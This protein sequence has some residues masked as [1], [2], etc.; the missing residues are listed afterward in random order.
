[1]RDLGIEIEIIRLY[2]YFGVGV[3]EG[4]LFV[5]L[6]FCKNLMVKPASAYLLIFLGVKS[7]KTLKVKSSKSW[8]SNLKEL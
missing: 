4:E 3:G 5:K 6:E 1:M 2:S 8:G 7:A